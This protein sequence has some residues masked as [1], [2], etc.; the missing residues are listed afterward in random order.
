MRLLT[1]NEVLPR[2]TQSG[3]AAPGI[4]EDLLVD[5]DCGPALRAYVALTDGRLGTD[6]APTDRF[7]NQYFW[8][9]RFANVYREKFGYDAGIEDQ[10]SQILA[11]AA[12]CDVDWLQMEQLELA[13]RA[14]QPGPPNS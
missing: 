8:F 14:R 5:A 10:E 12:H 13:A 11:E 2:V 1:D 7:Y 3:F 4:R 9:R 6:L